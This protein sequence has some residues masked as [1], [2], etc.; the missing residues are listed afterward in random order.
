MLNLDSVDPI[1]QSALEEDL[2]VGDL[3]TR[4]VVDPELNAE[5]KFYAKEALV[6][7]GWP[8]ATRTFNKVSSQVSMETRHPEGCHIGKGT[9]IGT[10]RGSVA[11]LLAGE[12]TALNFLQ[13]LSGIATLTREFVDRVSET[14]V[15]ILDTRKTTPVLRL[16]EKYAVR[17]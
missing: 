10:V 12:R 2:G 15:E 13:R 5:G 4:A 14:G 3:T 9:M 17:V 7:A 8:I 6:L 1:I 16:L 11:S